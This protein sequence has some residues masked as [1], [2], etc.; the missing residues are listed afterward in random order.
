MP[1]LHGGEKTRLAYLDDYIFVRQHFCDGVREQCDE[2][3]DQQNSDQ[4]HVDHVKQHEGHRIRALSHSHKSR[5]AVR[6]ILVGHMLSTPLRRL[7]V[8]ICSFDGLS[9]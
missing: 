8:I 2:E 3:V 6:L 7:V 4:E 1:F 9:L 5:N